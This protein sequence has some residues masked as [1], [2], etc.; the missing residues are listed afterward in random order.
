MTW[1]VR[2]TGSGTCSPSR[3]DSTQGSFPTTTRRHHHWSQTRSTNPLERAS[4]EIKRLTDVVGVFP[5]LGALLG[6]A[7]GAIVEQHDE[8][9][10]SE[11]RY[12][13]EQSMTLITTSD[14]K[15]EGQTTPPEPMTAYS[16]H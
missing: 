14:T 7:G 3:A 11:R 8:W 1:P 5:D 4:Q 9:V 2:G 6:L 16:D 12:F 15:S 10:A 13:S